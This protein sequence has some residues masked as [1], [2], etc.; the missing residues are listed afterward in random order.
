M[1][2]VRQQA[3]ARIPPPP[4]LPGPA[5]AIRVVRHVFPKL[6]KSLLQKRWRCYRRV[7]STIEP[8]PRLYLGGPSSSP[9]NISMAA[10]CEGRTELIG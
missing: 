10:T 9:L 5:A 3:G 8:Q 7:Y 6:R 1:K 2:R 4:A